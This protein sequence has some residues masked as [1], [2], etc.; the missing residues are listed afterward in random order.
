MT[1]LTFPSLSQTFRTEAKLNAPPTSGVIKIVL[2][3]N[4]MNNTV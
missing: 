4:D 2:L 1:A 3:I